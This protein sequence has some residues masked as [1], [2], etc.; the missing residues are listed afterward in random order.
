MHK[1]TPVINIVRHINPGNNNPLVGTND[2]LHVSRP[3]R[4]KLWSNVVNIFLYYKK[5]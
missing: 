5:N 4:P 1:S 2:E 3:I